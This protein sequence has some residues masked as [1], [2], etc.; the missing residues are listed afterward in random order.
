[1]EHQLVTYLIYF[2][3][4]YLINSLLCLSLFYYCKSKGINKGKEFYIKTIFFGIVFIIISRITKSNNRN[5]KFG[6]KSYKIKSVVFFCL[7]SVCIIGFISLTAFHFINIYF[8]K[9]YYDLYGN[10][11]NSVEDV[12]HYAENG[13]KYTSDIDNYCFIELDNPNNKIDAADCYIDKNGYFVIINH[14]N[15]TYDE[16]IP[17]SNPYCFYD[18]NNNYY[19]DALITSWNKNGELILYWNK[20]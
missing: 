16:K 13:K 5:F 20:P 1:M 11:Y 12:T 8:D 2:L 6:I 9:A 19:A 17:L 14:K 4:F 3:G 10:S 18:S 7:Y 15:L